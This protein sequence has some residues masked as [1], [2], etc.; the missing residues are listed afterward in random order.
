MQAELGRRLF[1]LKT[2]YDV[3]QHL[4]G[5]LEVEPALKDFLLMT[6]GNFGV[7]EGFVFVQDGEF[8]GDLT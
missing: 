7:V 2:L 3:R 5:T 8:P 6:M 4:L 1:H